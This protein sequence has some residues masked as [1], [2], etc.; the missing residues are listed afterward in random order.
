M[1]LRQNRKSVSLQVGMQ[2]GSRIVEHHKHTHLPRRKL[3]AAKGP[4]N[5]ST[6]ARFR[7][8]ITQDG[9]GGREVAANR[10]IVMP[11]QGTSTSAASN[12]STGTADWTYATIRSAES[13]VTRR[14]RRPFGFIHRTNTSP[15]AVATRLISFVV[16][17]ITTRR[18]LSKNVQ[19]I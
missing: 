11:M 5:L 16:L 10:C 13:T 8:S 7:A 4:A 12:T 1:Q 19:S 6:R 14:S 15:S 18:L 17:S 9:I 2:R 3:L